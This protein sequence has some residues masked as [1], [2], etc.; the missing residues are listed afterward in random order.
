MSRCTLVE[1][2]WEK[3]RQRC[4]DILELRFG[5]GI[6]CPQKRWTSRITPRRLLADYWRCHVGV[7]LDLASNPLRADAEVSSTLRTVG[8]WEGGGEGGAGGLSRSFPLDWLV[9]IY[10]RVCVWMN[11]FLC[12]LWTCLLL[13][14]VA[15]I[16]FWTYPFGT[17]ID[18]YFFIFYFFAISTILVLILDSF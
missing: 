2:R 5:R 10:V 3:E 9:Y 11:I 17:S 15:G 7:G 8:G 13:H 1:P 12:L 18:F 16:N 4:K 6:P 14:C